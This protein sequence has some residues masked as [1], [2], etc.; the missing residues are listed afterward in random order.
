VHARGACL[1]EGLEIVTR[2]LSGDAVD[3]EGDHFAVRSPP[4]LPRPVH[5]TIPIWVGGQWPNRAPFARAARYDGVVPRKV[6]G[7]LDVED[8]R[9]I[10]E[11]IGRAGDFDYV[12]SGSTA[13]PDDTEGV[14][15]WDGAGAT[16]WLE[17]RARRRDAQPRASRAASD[18]STR[19]AA[20]SRRAR[21]GRTRLLSQ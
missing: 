7:E 4:S 12:A 18:L 6:G 16:W 21:T 3:F 5:G 17:S 2:L 15:A 10:R 19:T 14:R 9:A 13:S 1:D 11:L 20:N 8:L